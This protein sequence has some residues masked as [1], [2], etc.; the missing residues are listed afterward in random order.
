MR[1]LVRCPS[2]PFPAFHVNLG[3][4]VHFS[5]AQKQEPSLWTNFYA[6]DPTH[7]RRP[8]EPSPWDF[9]ASGFGEIARSIPDAAPTF[10][11][12]SKKGRK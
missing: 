7:A 10:E 5:G 2:S 4:L 12:S 3:G 9:S 8:L 6:P 1:G 11:K